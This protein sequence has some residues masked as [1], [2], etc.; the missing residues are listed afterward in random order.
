MQT[1]QLVIFLTIF[2]VPCICPNIRWDGMKSCWVGTK[3]DLSSFFILQATF[4]LLR[5]LKSH[6]S[7]ST[8]MATAPAVAPV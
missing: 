1:M 5:E 8:G 3:Q 2:D 6:P 7:A 4:S